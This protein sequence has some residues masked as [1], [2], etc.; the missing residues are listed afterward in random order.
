MKP[1]NSYVLGCIICNVT[2]LFAAVI[3]ALWFQTGWWML[4]LILGSYSKETHLNIIE[5]ERT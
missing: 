5:K 2:L 4:L 1:S 3:L